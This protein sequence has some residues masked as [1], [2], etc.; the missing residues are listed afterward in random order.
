[1]VQTI[2]QGMQIFLQF[3]NICIILF[4]FYKFLGKPRDTLEERVKA[5]EDKVEEHD[6]ALKRDYK[7]FNG[8][9][10]GLTIITKSII[11]LIDWEYQYCI[12]EHKEMSSSLEKARTDLNDYLAGKRGEVL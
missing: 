11:A 7:R 4:G 5:L 2:S 9:D 1:M 6:D 10:D 8:H 3:A 12:T